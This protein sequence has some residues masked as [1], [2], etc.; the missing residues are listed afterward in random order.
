[1]NYFIC[2]FNKLRSTGHFSVIGDMEALLVWTK[3]IKSGTKFYTFYW[4]FTEVKFCKNGSGMIDARQFFLT[5]HSLPK[6]IPIST[7]LRRFDEQLTTNENFCP[8][9]TIGWNVKSEISNGE[10]VY[11][12]QF[13]P[14]IWRPPNSRM[15]WRI[16]HVHHKQMRFRLCCSSTLYSRS[17]ITG[18]GPW[19]WMA[20]LKVLFL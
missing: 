13:Y 17:N 16:G 8:T 1:M 19:W 4:S 12:W 3:R 11:L 10:K 18:N 6:N 7:C 15:G 20:T 5:L 9:S 2:I 14:Q